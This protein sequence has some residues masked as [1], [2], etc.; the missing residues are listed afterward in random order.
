[1]LR[2]ASF[3]VRMAQKRGITMMTL[4][5]KAAAKKG[6]CHRHPEITHQN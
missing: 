2:V 5:T 1:M 3:P 6:S 4:I